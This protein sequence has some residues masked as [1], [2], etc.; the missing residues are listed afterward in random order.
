MQYAWARWVKE[1]STQ[2]FEDLED[3][4]KRFGAADNRRVTY[5]LEL[6]KDPRTACSVNPETLALDTNTHIH[7][8]KPYVSENS[9][10]L[11][12][13]PAVFETEPRENTEL[14]VYYEASNAIPLKLDDQSKSNIDNDKG[15]ILA[16]VGSKVYANFP[17]VQWFNNS[18]IN[19]PLVQAWDGDVLEL[20]LGLK[21][22]TNATNTNDAAGLAAQSTAWAGKTIRIYRSDNDYVEMEVADSGGVIEIEEVTGGTNLI[23]KIKLKPSV[24][25]VGLNYFNCYSFGNGVESNRIRD[26]FN[27]PFISNGVKASTTLEEGYEVDN[28]TNGLIYSGLY[29]KNA[30]VNNLNQFIAA[31]K[32]TKD[33]L[34]TYGSIQKLYARN[35]DLVALCED[36]IVQI[37][38]DKDALFNADGNMQLVSTNKV[39]GQSRPFVGDYGISKNPESFAAEG[40][41]AYFTDKQ[42]VFVS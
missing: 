34:P 8:L 35:S 11:S 31:E 7:F 9:T 37:L 4:V 26:D 30:K 24:K 18:A 22:D 17:A 33:L 21:V 15:Y 20:F 27:Q 29:N 25:K 28:R 38:A 19:T 2:K 1:P 41:R 6:D 39:L 14:D 10:V 13:N 5:I 32:I 3:A 36:K 23:K 42:S 12:D 40:Y 16:P